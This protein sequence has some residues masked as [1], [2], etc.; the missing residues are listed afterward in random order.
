MEIT[1]PTTKNMPKSK[2]LQKQIEN[3]LDKLQELIDEIVEAQSIN[4]D[5]PDTWDSDTLYNL[6]ENLKA[7]LKLLEDQESKTEKDHLGQPL[8]LEEGICS[9]VDEYQSE[10]ED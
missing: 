2:K 3:K 8:I 7:A 6:I 9:L 1:P 5:D 4:S 10:E